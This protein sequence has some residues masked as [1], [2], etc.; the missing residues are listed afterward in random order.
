MDNAK[1]LEQILRINPQ[2]SVS[3]EAIIMASENYKIIQI[4]K[5]I[6]TYIKQETN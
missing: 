2:V 1:G 6:E 4:H 5:N 3:K